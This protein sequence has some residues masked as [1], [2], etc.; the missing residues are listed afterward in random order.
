MCKRVM[1]S[2]ASGLA[3]LTACVAPST[4]P[5]APASSRGEASQ[6]TA[7]PVASPQ[8]ERKQSEP[9]V[10]LGAAFERVRE[11]PVDESINVWELAGAPHMP[12]IALN[13]S[14]GVVLLSH[15]DGSI[16]GLLP[17]KETQAVAFGATQPYLAVLTTQALKV[18]AL[19]TKSTMPLLNAA[20]ALD[21]PLASEQTQLLGFS[22]RDSVVLLAEARVLR[23]YSLRS[24]ELAFEVALPVEVGLSDPWVMTPDE[25]LLFYAPPKGDL[26][27]VDVANA[28]VSGRIAFNPISALALSPDGKRLAVAEN[29]VVQNDTYGEVLAP[30]RLGVW[31]VNIGERGVELSLLAELPFDTEFDGENL[32]VSLQWLQFYPGERPLLLGIA[33]WQGEGNTPS[34][35]LLWDLATNEQLARHKTENRIAGHALADPNGTLATYQLTEGIALWSV[36]QNR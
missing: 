6:A 20:V 9:L 29:R 22:P 7:T 15:H 11:L 5:T 24:G 25:R 16:A 31:E 27:V 28:V 36:K 14:E 18:F 17:L 4:I 10:T 26:L 8:P 33:H 21:V 23:G 13:T 32:P 19:D 1:A 3:L 12:W 2:L 34:R 35:M 30:S